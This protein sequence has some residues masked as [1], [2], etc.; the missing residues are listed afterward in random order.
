MLRI[1]QRNIEINIHIHLINHS[2]LLRMVKYAYENTK[3]MN[4]AYRWHATNILGK[5]RTKYERKQ[6]KS[7]YYLLASWNEVIRHHHSNGREISISLYDVTSRF[8]LNLSMW[9][10]LRYFPVFIKFHLISSSSSR[11]ALPHLLY[12][13]SY[14]SCCGFSHSVHQSTPL[15]FCVHPQRDFRHDYGWNENS[16]SL[17]GR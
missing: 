5:K 3:H 7:Y 8:W 16:S 6:A 2:H 10:H 13:C 12:C 1:G 15:W 4:R 11:D 17:L 14:S 9:C